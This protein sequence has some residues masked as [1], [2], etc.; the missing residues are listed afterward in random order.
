MA[1]GPAEPVLLRKAG[2]GR[3]GPAPSAAP[4]PAPPPPSGVPPQPTHCELPDLAALT[5]VVVI[6]SLYCKKAAVAP[7]SYS[8]ARCASSCAIPVHKLN[9]N[10]C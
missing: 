8:A 10:S 6:L 3:W 5:S 4:Q 1:A 9:C 7:A 2:G